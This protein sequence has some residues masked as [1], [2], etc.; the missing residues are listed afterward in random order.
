MIVTCTMNPAIDLFI[1]TKKLEAGKV[2]RTENNDI[3]PNGKGVNVSFVLKMLGVENT[4]TGFIGGFTGDF[5]NE[6]LINKGIQTNFVTVDE[7]TRINVFTNVLEEKEEYKIVNKGPKI[8]RES[9]QELINILSELAKGDM[10]VVSGSNPEGINDADLLEIA[11]LCQEREVR[12]V[13]DTSSPI[14]LEIINYHP[15]CIKPNEE[16]LMQLFNIKELTEDNIKYYG[17]YLVELGAENV[18]VSLGSKGAILF[19]KETILRGN[20]PKGELVN[21]ACAGD[22]MLGTFIALKEKGYVDDSALRTAIAA[23]SSTAFTEGL[24]DF[25]DVPEL[26]N[27]IEIRK[28]MD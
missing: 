10:L 7:T 18:I 13:I 6:E 16:E 20:A 21:S 1:S 24:T 22:T 3:Q 14:L 4:A 25:D 8:S 23:A 12:L 19:N 11:K 5:I 15:Y 2:N 9:F 28:V 17:K 27:E 26:E